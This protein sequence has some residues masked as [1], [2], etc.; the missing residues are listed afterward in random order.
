MTINFTPHRGRRRT[1]PWWVVRA[2]TAGAGVLVILAGAL[3]APAVAGA[4]TPDPSAPFQLPKFD[5]G[6][7]TTWSTMFPGGT[8]DSGN[9]LRT[10]GVACARPAPLSANDA[11]DGSGQGYRV[12]FIMAL[13]DGR[14]LA[15]Y[16]PLALKAGQYPFGT[17]AIG[18][19]GWVRGWVE[20]P[21]LRIVVPED[22][23]TMCSGAGALWAGSG[24]PA[25]P[26]MFDTLGACAGCGGGDN[27]AW[28]SVDPLGVPQASITGVTS[29]GALEFQAAMTVRIHAATGGQS[30]S[31]D[32]D[33]SAVVDL[34]LGT[35]PKPLVSKFPLIPDVLPAD[36]SQWA[37]QVSYK[38]YYQN[39]FDMRTTPPSR[40][41]MPPR[42]LAGAIIGQS[43]TVADVTAT[44]P[45]LAPPPGSTK[46]CGDGSGPEGNTLGSFLGRALSPLSDDNGSQQPAQP[47]NPPQCVPG[48]Q[49]G[50]VAWFTLIKDSAGLALPYTPSGSMQTSV[51]ITIADIGMHAG[52]PA[53]FGFSQ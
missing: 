51:D 23:T 43:A 42:P 15:E 49:C 4:S 7:A 30:H 37:S 19:T 9:F 3:L 28:S 2:S 26:G 50:G 11:G 40:Y 41:Y 14:A 1:R 21:S 6:V 12:P 34:S 20:L 47:T 38:R 35:Q 31:S 16:S 27:D 39:P 13:T 52:V 45:R 25:K 5:K 18:V 44:V 46:L 10:G 48:S 8:D 17:A 53:G 22:G 32:L 33:C 24:D 29:S 36:S